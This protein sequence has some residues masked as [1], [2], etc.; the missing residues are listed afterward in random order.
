MTTKASTPDVWTIVTGKTEKKTKSNKPKTVLIAVPVYKNTDHNFQASLDKLMSSKTKH[1]YVSFF[2]RGDSLID[3]ARATL[4]AAFLNQDKLDQLKKEPKF[5]YMLQIDSDISFDWDDVDRFVDVAV[6]GY[7]VLG[8]P[9]S[10]KTDKRQFPVCRGLE[11]SVP[12]KDHIQEVKY[13]G[14]GWLMMSRKAILDVCKANEHLSYYT[15]P[16][17]FPGFQFKTYA[18]YQPLPVDQWGTDKDGQ[19]MREYLSEDYALCYRLREIGYKIYLDL[20]LKT[21]HW[22]NNIGY[23]LSRNVIQG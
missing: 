9:Y 2:V 10:F 8:G 3:R 21:T 23:Q 15:N 1:K 22:N 17:T 18:I 19:P 14:T 4:L 11:G 5:D 13:Q 7:D 16:D 20:R 12:S 6:S